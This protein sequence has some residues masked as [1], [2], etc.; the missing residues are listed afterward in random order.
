MRQTPPLGVW[1]R[2]KNAKLKMVQTPL[3]Y[4]CR[5]GDMELVKDY[6]EGRN[7]CVSCPTGIC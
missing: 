1:G 5:D 6:V 3:H 7:G 4:A 2:N